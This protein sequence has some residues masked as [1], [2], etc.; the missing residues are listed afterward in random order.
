M[1]HVKQETVGQISSIEMTA[2][3]DEGV[4]LAQGRFLD[5]L[6]G[7]VFAGI[8]LLWVVSSLAGLMWRE[9]PADV[10]AHFQSLAHAC[11]GS[12]TLTMMSRVAGAASFAK[13][14]YGFFDPRTPA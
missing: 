9:L 5:A 3:P 13:T 12:H 14:A 4:R 2:E 7:A 10:I 6:P 1:E 11:L 8:T